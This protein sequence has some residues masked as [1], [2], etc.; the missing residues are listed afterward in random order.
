MHIT[1]LTEIDN[2]KIFLNPLNIKYSLPKRRDWTAFREEGPQLAK[3]LAPLVLR[4]L[5]FT[6][7]I[8][9]HLNPDNNSALIDFIF[10][11]IQRL[12]DSWKLFIK[13][14]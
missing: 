6:R 5:R 3:I 2:A 4:D 13:L 7:Y 1:T 8:S 11:W 9:I 12:Y 14:A 10:E